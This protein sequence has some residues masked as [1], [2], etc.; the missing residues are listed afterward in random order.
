MDLKLGLKQ[1]TEVEIKLEN[2]K[3]NFRKNLSK[4]NFE[5]LN[6]CI[7]RYLQSEYL[8]NY[9]KTSYEHKI[10]LECRIKLNVLFVSFVK[11]I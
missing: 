3:S 2:M 11:S 10:L 1:G 7:V 6:Y 8:T 9:R 5:K 4:I